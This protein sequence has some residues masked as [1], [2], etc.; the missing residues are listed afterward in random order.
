MARD[1]KVPDW[2]KPQ[3]PKQDEAT[4]TDWL[5]V[6]ADALAPYATAATLGAAAGA[7]FGGVGAGPGAGAGVVSLGLADLGTGAY[8]IVSPMFGGQ[9]LPLPSETLRRPYRALGVTQA[10][11]TPGQQVYSDVLSSAAGGYTGAKGA[12]Q[13]ENLMLSPSG[14]NFMKFLGQTPGAQAAAGGGGAALPSVAAN[15]FN[16]TDPNAL[17]GL[18][19]AGSMAG[20]KMA[21]PS[22]RI[23]TVNELTARANTA[24][25]AVKKAGVKIS[26]PALTQL[27]TDIDAALLDK[28][29]VLANHPEVRTKL[30]VLKSELGAGPIDLKRLDSLHSDLA[31]KARTIR[32]DKT[33]MYM[34]T[35][36]HKVEDFID[37]LTPAQVT[38]GNAPAA[39]KA[40]SQAQQLWKQKKELTQLDDAVAA[41]RTR[42]ERNEM[43]FGDALVSEFRKIQDSKRFNRLSPNVQEAVI[44][45]ANGTPTK[46]ALDVIGSLSPSNKKALAGEFLAGMGVWAAT[47]HA[48]AAAVLGGTAATF[49]AT[50]KTAANRMAVAG[51]NRA[52][53][54]AAGVQPKNQT[55]F[56]ILSPA[57][58]QQATMAQ[59]RGRTAT[60]R[61]DT[62]E[63]PYWVMKK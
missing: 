54:T 17:M 18:S 53:A 13:L 44:A 28:D 27:S 37:K 55:P 4:A 16:V 36:S 61:R 50:A 6:T 26:Q 42:V 11:A 62:Y 45:V 41:A 52:R 47:Q 1:D 24:Y 29:F 7:P 8:N 30:R 33:R 5:K 51:A 19:L 14:Q 3:T 9:R 25:D 31:A 60:Q 20:G 2:A 32:D 38:A 46:R 15:Y 43:S 56:Y 34:E 63:P 35:L 10:P 48:P 23:P 39:T 57:A 40:L 21:T 49:G 22:P 58:Q 12:Q 59:E